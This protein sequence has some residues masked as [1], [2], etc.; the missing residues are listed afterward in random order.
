[1]TGLAVKNVTTD[2][3]DREPISPEEVQMKGEFSVCQFFQDGTYDYERR[4]VSAEDA[5][6][7]WRHL[8]SSVGAQLGTTQRV[9]ITDGGDCINMEWEY[10][11]GQTYPRH[12]GS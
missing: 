11:K 9:I 2:Q 8:T 5:V 6:R 12:T 7:I 4:F 10:G 3:L 1:M